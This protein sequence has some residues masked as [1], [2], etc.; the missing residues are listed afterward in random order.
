MVSGLMF[1]ET[2]TFKP[3]FILLQQNITTMTIYDKY[4]IEKSK[5][6]APKGNITKGDTYTCHRGITW[7]A[8]LVDFVDGASLVWVSEPLSITQTIKYAGNS[9]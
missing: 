7:I 1:T 4:E 8:K 3:K 5:Q 2:K 9:N 6:K